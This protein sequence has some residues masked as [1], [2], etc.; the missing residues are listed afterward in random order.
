MKAEPP[1]AQSVKPSRSFTDKDLRTGV[2]YS[3]P[4]STDFFSTTDVN[5]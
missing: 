5:H 1:E 2:A 3:I 4:C